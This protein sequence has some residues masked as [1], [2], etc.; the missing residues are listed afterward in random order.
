MSLD[1]SYSRADTQTLLG[2]GKTKFW[3]LVSKGE[4]PNAF[5][6]GQSIRVPESDIKAYKDKYRVEIN[7]Y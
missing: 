1:R 6:V 5:K 4:F 3:D 7:N 2:C